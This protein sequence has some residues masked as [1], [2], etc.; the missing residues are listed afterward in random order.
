MTHGLERSREIPERETKMFR[1]SDG[2][3]FI[4]IMRLVTSIVNRPILMYRGSMRSFGIYGFHHKAATTHHSR[5]LVC[6]LDNLIP[7]NDE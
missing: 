6:V 2:L 1:L 5:P 7:I 3:S 4:S